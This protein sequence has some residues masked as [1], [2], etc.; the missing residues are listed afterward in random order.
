MS[1]TGH[2]EASNKRLTLTVTE[3]GR[4]MVTLNSG[5]T[6][7]QLVIDSKTV[8]VTDTHSGPMGRTSSAVTINTRSTGIADEGFRIKQLADDEDDKEISRSFEE[9][10]SHS[11]SKSQL[12]CS[13]QFSMERKQST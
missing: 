6:I 2:L 3:K 13:G 5:T 12:V 4:W 8:G 1:F 11:G 7:Q 9:S 10:G